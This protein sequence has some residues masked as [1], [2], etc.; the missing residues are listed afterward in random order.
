MAS[1]DWPDLWSV[2]VS[3]S[4]PADAR[5]TLLRVHAELFV[6][7]PA[8]DGEAIA[9]FEAIALGFVPH[10]TQTVLADIA[11]LVAPCPDTPATVLDALAQ[12]FPETRDIVLELAPRLPPTVVDLLLGSSRDRSTLAARHDL[13]ERTLRRLLELHDASIDEAL[14]ANLAL[15]PGDAGFIE[16]IERA[17]RNPALARVLLARGDL[18]VPDQ[19]A[20]YLYADAE[21]RAHIRSHV[22]ASAL[23]QRPHLP[24]RVTPAKSDELLAAAQRGDVATLEA[25]LTACFGL[26]S[27]IEWR[28]IQKDRH[29]LLPLALRA[30]GVEEEDAIRILLTLHPAVSHSVGTVFALVRILR[31]VARPTALALVEAILAART[32][33]APTGRHQPAMDPSSTP[34]AAHQAQ[35]ERPRRRADDL[36]RLRG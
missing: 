12:R 2:A 3:E 18:P 35:T 11:R 22:A 17:R 25:Q 26:P 24:F 19:A 34:V 27:R 31:T 16:L 6:S 21:K 23:F 14:A 29:E 20:L 7:A 13:D 15:L 10:V 1:S 28:L 4:D 9:S 8:R 32:A 5:A 33:F 36:Q 30:L